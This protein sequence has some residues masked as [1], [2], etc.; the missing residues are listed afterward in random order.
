MADRTEKVLYLTFL[1]GFFTCVHLRFH[2]TEDERRQKA[3]S[4]VL[5]SLYSSVTFK[6]KI[7][8]C[9]VLLLLLLL[10]HFRL[11]SGL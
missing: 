5:L 9:N 11:S 1:V 2:Y 10:G 8:S 4:Y 7:T 3:F 6:S